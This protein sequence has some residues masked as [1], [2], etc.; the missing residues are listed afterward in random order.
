MQPAK[1]SAKEAQ[2]AWMPS[3][4]RAPTFIRPS[5]CPEQALYQSYIAGLVC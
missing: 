1:M 4:G 5:T 3:I 2:L